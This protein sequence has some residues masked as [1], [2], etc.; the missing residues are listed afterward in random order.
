MGRELAEAGEGDE[1]VGVAGV[2]DETFNELGLSELAG[3]EGE[4]GAGEGEEGES[5]VLVVGGRVVRVVEVRDL[6]AERRGRWRGVGV[7]WL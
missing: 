7:R 5:G 4:S 6:E 1:W 2:L 3:G